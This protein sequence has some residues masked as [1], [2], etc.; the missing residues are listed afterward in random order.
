RGEDELADLA[1]AFNVFLGKIY[2]TVEQ[3]VNS[4][5]QVVE[6]VHKLEDLSRQTTEEM[7]RQQEDT[8]QAATATTQMSATIQDV[9][10][11]A[12]STAE[13][14]DQARQAAT[15]G[16][17]V[18][19]ESINSINKLA[20]KITHAGEVIQM[21]ES[22]SDNIGTILDVIQGIA[23][24]TNLLALNAAI[25][26]ARA[27]DQGRGFA[28]VADEVRTLAQRTRSST[29][30]IQGII[31]G[32]QSGSKNAVQVMGEGKQQ[33]ETSVEHVRQTN[34]SF[35]SISNAITFISDMNTQIA[36]ATEEQS[37]VAEEISRN[38]ASI[39]YTGEQIVTHA[40]E[41]SV[42][43]EKLSRLTEQLHNAVSHF[44]I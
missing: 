9:V 4:V 37:S 31:E 1:H 16:K 41:S 12:T 2:R 23:D 27:G 28:V 17:Q 29:T 14:A 42:A 26:A 3:V 30:E 19:N 39:S 22:K 40:Q 13:S 18:V 21:L 10:K 25:E 33:V 11:N 5:S 38:V 43:T 44:K 36:S 20:E 24:Q 8:E 34:E 35:E 15:E 7:T 32:L 6:S